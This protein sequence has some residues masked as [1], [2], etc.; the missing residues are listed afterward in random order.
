MALNKEQQAL[1]IQASYG[2]DTLS[3]RDAAV[4]LYDQL[5]SPEALP[6]EPISAELPSW[7]EVNAGALPT[8]D[9][10][11]AHEEAVKP[12]LDYDVMDS[13]PDSLKVG[14]WSIPIDKRTGAFF[15]GTGHAM[16]WVYPWSKAAS[17]H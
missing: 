12:E 13:L 8:W 11:Q 15:V 16:S 1:A 9:Q 3:Q 17:W 7:D 4:A 10:V 14:L 5:D 6:Q 2:D